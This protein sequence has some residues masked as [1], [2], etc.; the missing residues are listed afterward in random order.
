MESLEQRILEALKKIRDPITG[1]AT[2]LAEAHIAVQDLGDGVV[3]I[4][5][6]PTNPYSPT[7]LTQAEA[8]KTAARKV[9]GVKRVIIDC[10]NHIMAQLITDRLNT[11]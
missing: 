4:L 1:A 7:A 6:I 9:P 8:V 5:F 11:T 3:K 2:L 10:R